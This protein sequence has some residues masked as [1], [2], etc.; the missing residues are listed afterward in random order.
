MCLASNQDPVSVSSWVAG[1]N[2]SQAV[3]HL[4][5]LLVHCKCVYVCVYMCVFMA[6]LHVSDV[7][8]SVLSRLPQCVFCKPTCMHACGGTYMIICCWSTVYAALIHLTL[9]KLPQR[10]PLI[11]PQRRLYLCD[12]GKQAREIVSTCSAVMSFKTTLDLDFFF[13]RPHTGKKMV[14]K[15]AFPS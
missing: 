11:F 12:F 9:Y 5:E 2:W 10:I 3:Q 1:R 13:F 15:A 14:E 7:L 6:C 4:H 8:M